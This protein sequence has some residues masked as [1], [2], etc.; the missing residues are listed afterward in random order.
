MFIQHWL[1]GIQ[2]RIQFRAAMVI[3][4]VHVGLILSIVGLASAPREQMG[5]SFHYLLAGVISLYGGIFMA[6]FFVVWPLYSL[7]QKARYLM[8]WREWIWDEL[9][10]LIAYLPTLLEMF[11]G[12]RSK[13]QTSSRSE[14]QAPPPASP[15]GTDSCCCSCCSSGHCASQHCQAHSSRRP[16]PPFH[17]DEAHTE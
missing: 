13:T 1:K 15:E 10:K 2:R 14:H 6:A 3:L 16:S 17:S 5:A 8:R 11:R 12:L 4:L 9:P 7:V